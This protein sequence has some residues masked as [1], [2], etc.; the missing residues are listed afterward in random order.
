MISV[1]ANIFV[2]A[3]YVF[4]LVIEFVFTR[5][6]YRSFSTPWLI[7]T[8]IYIMFIIYQILIKTNEQIEKGKVKD[9]SISGYRQNRLLRQIEKI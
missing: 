8:L 7:T 1:T 6:L 4:L 2:F 3:A 9:L 5:V